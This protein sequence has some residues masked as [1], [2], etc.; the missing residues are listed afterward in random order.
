[1]TKVSVIIPSFNLGRFVEQ[2]LESVVDQ[3]YPD[4]EI[5]VVDGASRDNT[6]SILNRYP[7]VR[8]Y[9][10]PDSGIV[11]ALQKGVMRSTGDLVMF[12]MI[13]DGY[14]DPTWIS[15]CVE[16]L[17]THSQTSLCF[18]L[19]QYMSEDGVLGEVSYKHWLG[20]AAPS[21]VA[22]FEHWLATGWHFPECNMCIR[23]QVV[24]RIFQ[25]IDPTD[26]SIDVFLKFTYGFHAAGYLSGFIPIV[27]NFGRLHSGQRGE[28]ERLSGVLRQR[29][30]SYRCARNRF[31]ENLLAK[32]TR[33]TF[34][35]SNGSEVG[36]YRP[37]LSKV[38]VL[39]TRF[40]MGVIKRRF[41]S[42]A[43]IAVGWA[44]LQRG[45]LVRKNLNLSPKLD[46]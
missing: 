3:D 31:I 4:L 11:E 22:I 28:T 44:R 24:N 10:E 1:M 16:F 30:T 15:K 5:I 2:T 43:I 19:P 26:E 20:H 39:M 33:L 32:R 29:E 12:M 35:S 18:G 25:T 13:S 40:T 17:E 45:R 23:K 9:S 38:C 34:R 27:A 37:S 21:N 6:L 42:L 7:T 46:S 14:L 8:L 36:V 41:L